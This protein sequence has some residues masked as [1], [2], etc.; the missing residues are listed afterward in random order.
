MDNA[1]KFTPAG[2]QVTIGGRVHGEHIRLRVTDTGVGI[3]EDERERVFDRFYQVQSG[4]TRAYRGT[5]LGLT[6]CKHIVER[7]HGRIWIE[8]SEGSGA[9]FVVEL[10]RELPLERELALDFSNLPSRNQPPPSS[11]A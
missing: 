3:P 1:I 5:G 9:V 6:I 4:S 10:P 2:G 7:H 11:P 8:D